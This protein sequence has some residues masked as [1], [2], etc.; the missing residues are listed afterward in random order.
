MHSGKDVSY[1]VDCNGP[2]FKDEPLAIAGCGNAAA[3]GA[4]AMVLY[5]DDIHLISEGLNVGGLPRPKSL[6]KCHRSS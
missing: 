6:E 1:G 3:S 2:L 5:T 4:L